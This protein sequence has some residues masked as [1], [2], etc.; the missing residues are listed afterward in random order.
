MKCSYL[1]LLLPFILMT[2]LS[3]DGYK[4]RLTEIS[5]VAVEVRIIRSDQ[6]ARLSDNEI[7]FLENGKCQL[8]EILRFDRRDLINQPD[9]TWE[10]FKDSEHSY[11]LIK[12]RNIFNGKYIYYLDNDPST[13]WKM[14][15][16]SDSL[17]II[18]APF[19]LSQIK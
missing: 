18:C 5:W 4:A 19:C 8:P 11:V 6:T 2:A 3:C 1:K 10:Y 7:R 14:T 9:A 17:K 12:S 13:A 16:I 15:L